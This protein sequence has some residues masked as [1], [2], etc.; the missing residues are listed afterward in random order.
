MR[1]GDYT[2]IPF[3]R[4]MRGPTDRWPAGTGGGSVC[5]VLFAHEPMGDGSMLKQVI[6]AV[7]SSEWLHVALVLMVVAA[8]LQLA[9]LS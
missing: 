2:Q 6:T 7:A 4:E 9:P 1:R 5:H 3:L 8:T